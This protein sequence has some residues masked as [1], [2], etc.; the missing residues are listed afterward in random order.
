[1]NTKE[2]FKDFVKNHPEL[3]DHINNK[4]K[5]W[6]DFYEMYDIY[7]DNEKVWQDFLKVPKTNITN[8]SS[9]LINFLK[10][11]DLDSIEEGVNSVQRVIGL[12]QDMTPNNKENPQPR[13][14]R[15]LYKHFDD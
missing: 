10:T 5:T 9:F 13:R 3:L 1:M 11:I 8:T 4:N 7:G 6:Q 14:P 12:L 15:P 2:K